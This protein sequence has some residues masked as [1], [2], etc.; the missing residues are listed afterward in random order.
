MRVRWSTFPTSVRAERWADDGLEGPL[1]ISVVI[2]GFHLNQVD[3]MVAAA[4]RAATGADADVTWS[5][6]PEDRRYVDWTE[7]CE[8]PLGVLIVVGD[9]FDPPTFREWV[10]CFARRLLGEG[11]DGDVCGTTQLWGLRPA[12]ASGF[13]W[14]GLATL[15]YRLP[16]DAFDELGRN[17]ERVGP[18]EP[19]RI[20]GTAMAWLRADGD[21]AT[22]RLAPQ[23]GE[24][25]FDCPG[26]AAE[27]FLRRHLAIPGRPIST[28]ELECG[29]QSPTRLVWASWNGVM[30]F[31]CLPVVDDWKHRVDSCIPLIRREAAHLDFAE[32]PWVY[33]RLYARHLLTQY[34]VE[35][36]GIM[37]LRDA[38]LE[39]AARLDDWVVERV[40]DD[41]WL[42]QARDLAPWFGP[43][44]ATPDLAVQA[45]HDFG[46]ALVIDELLRRGLPYAP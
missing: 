31:D 27:Q 17:L 22:V 1:S 6:L 18:E 29:P 4:E 25:G 36:A 13:S 40:S 15:Y 2:E 44:L 37:L 46:P 11:I 9:A 20:L 12:A 38:H 21:A 43:E 34:I 30:R 8:S 42:V 16:E 26:E 23:V 35:P 24:G 32:A 7:V 39:K 28:V 45:R 10:L 33:P 3:E 14:S 19:D 5:D 41:R